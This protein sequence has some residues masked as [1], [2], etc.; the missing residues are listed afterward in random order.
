MTVLMLAAGF[1]GIVLFE[2]GQTTA[3]GIAGVVTLVF[4]AL[5]L[6]TVR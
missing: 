1:A 6:R 5:G 4:L 3:A 2:R